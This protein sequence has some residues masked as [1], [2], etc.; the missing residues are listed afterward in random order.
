M[1]CEK[2]EENLMARFD[3]LLRAAASG[4]A[5]AQNELGNAYANGVGTV[6]NARKAV[7]WYSR[8][9]AQGQTEAIGNLGFC[10]LC[11]DGVPRDTAEGARLISEAIKKG[12]VSGR[13]LYQLATCYESGE[14]VASDRP[15]AVELYRESASKGYFK[16]NAALRRL[17][18]RG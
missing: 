6:P 4:D 3:A 16:A 11:G 15:R 5:V 2:P 17:Q 14:G 7:E 10:K 12:D 8:S 13:N 1:G 18:K 9:A